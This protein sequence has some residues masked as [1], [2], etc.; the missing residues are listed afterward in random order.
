MTQRMTKTTAFLIGVLVAACSAD[1]ARTVAPALTHAPIAVAFAGGT[2]DYD[3]T[4]ASLT[5]AG[6]T[7]AFDEPFST[8]LSKW[9]VWEGGAFNNELQ[10]YQA[11]NL[12]VANGILSI[13]A[14]RE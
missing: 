7:K 1:P 14:R 3:Q 6:W 12:Q 2:C 13:N 4:D 9:K 10:H 5:I 11:S 8:N